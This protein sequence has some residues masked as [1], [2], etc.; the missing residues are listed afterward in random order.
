MIA[1]TTAPI[2]ACADTNGVPP[3]NPAPT[4]RICPAWCVEHVEVGGNTTLMHSSGPV[5]IW[6]EFEGSATASLTLTTWLD[7]SPTGRD[8]DRAAL[9]LNIGEL[10]SGDCRDVAAALLRMADQLDG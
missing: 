4:A 6:P 10:D 1:Q 8:E 3:T 7:G 2:Q 9:D 5:P